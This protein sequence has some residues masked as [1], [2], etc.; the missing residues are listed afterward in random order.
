M[1]IAVIGSGNVATHLAQLFCRH[2]H[3][4][5][6]V[7]SRT[8]AHARILADTVSAQAVASLTELNIDTDLILIAVSDDAIAEIV[9]QLPSHSKAIVVHTSG[10]TPMDILS[11]FGQCGVIYPPQ[12][13]NKKAEADLTQIPFAVE[14]SSKRVEDRLLAMMTQIASKSFLCSSKQRLALH[15]AAVFANN[16]S[17]A[18][19]Q[20]AYDILQQ[21]NLDFDLVRP[22]ILETAQKV[23]NYIPEQVQTGPALRNDR[24]IIELHLQFLRNHPE[25]AEI[26]QQLTDFIVKSRRKT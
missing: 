21:E 2:G 11:S 8:V 19:Y 4:I 22:L 6:Q 26:Y 12:S 17:N 3:A 1:N 16:F 13:L 10:S 9:V 25:Q 5:T 18:L 15:V 20:M 14:G 23:Q 24:K 7:Y